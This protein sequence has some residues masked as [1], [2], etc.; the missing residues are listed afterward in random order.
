MKPA[1]LFCG[2][3]LA[4]MCSTIL[5]TDAQ[6]QSV[7]ATVGQWADGAQLFDGL[8]NFHRTITTSSKEAQAYFDQGMRLLW[9]FNHDESSRSFAKAAKLDPGCA[10][11]FWG[12]SLTVGPN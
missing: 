9:A 11:C 8:G 6:M 5:P 3:A 7:P 2:G 4:A 1:M 10:M 12:V